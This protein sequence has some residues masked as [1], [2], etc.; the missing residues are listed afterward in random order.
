MSGFELKVISPDKAV[1]EGECE[2]LVFE[3]VDGKYGIMR[4][5]SP[6]TAAIKPGKI[7]ILSHGEEI[8]VETGSGILRF[9]NNN[10]LIIIE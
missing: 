3:T 6:V 4:G 10:A 1:F 8:F 2:S 9:E 5:H 7:K